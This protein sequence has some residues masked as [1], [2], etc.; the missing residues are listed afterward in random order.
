MSFDNGPP[1]KRLRLHGCCGRRRLSARLR[2]SGDRGVLACAAS[3]QGRYQTSLLLFL[4]AKGAAQL[5][6][7]HRF[8]PTVLF[9]GEPSGLLPS[10]LRSLR[11]KFISRRDASL[12]SLAPDQGSPL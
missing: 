4:D 10:I 12:P 11:N 8:V 3:P 1:E 6:I 2:T 5:N 7:T 9:L